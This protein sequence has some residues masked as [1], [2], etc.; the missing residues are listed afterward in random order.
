MRRVAAALA[1]LLLV[2]SEADADRTHRVRSGDTLTTIA[3]RYR[4]SVTELRRA[5]RLRGDRIRIGQ[6]L[7]VPGGRASAAAARRAGYHVVRR[8]QTLSHISRRYRVSVR[9]LQ[10]ANGLRSTRIRAGM[11]LRIPGRRR[12]N[13]LPRLPPRPPR[14]DQEEAIVRAQSLGLGT[15]RCAQNL[16]KDPPEDRWVAAAAAAPHE[17][18]QHAY[19]VGTP[20]VPDEE[21]EEAPLEEA[22][23]A[24]EP[25]EDT[26]TE[27]A[28]GPEPPDGPG[29]LQ[30]PVDDA[31]YLRGWGSGRGGYHLAIDIAARGGINT[32]IRAAE[33]GIVAYTGTGVRGYGRFVIVVHPN[34]WVTAY[35]HNRE[36]LVV[37]GE[38]V[39]RGQILAL[40]GNTGISRG[41]HVHFMLMDLGE[42]CDPLPLFRPLIRFRNDR[43]VETEITTWTDE[44]PAEVRCLP[45]SARPYPGSR[46]RRRGRRR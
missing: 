40:L 4:V 30:L 37:P 32:P 27:G 20:I 22:E 38:L 28:D 11:R 8:G 25:L 10:R 23:D 26:A 41:P 34:G 42:H 29:T 43:R 13:P 35:A 45:R 17:I 14:H 24:D 15:D 5:N 16:I 7:R 19:G 39:A 46:R 1:L 3:R 21:E 18:P 36:M 33:R 9:R 31:I 44:R 2:G 12:E 6:Q